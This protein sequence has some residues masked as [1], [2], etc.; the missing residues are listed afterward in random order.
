MLKSQGTRQQTRD[1]GGKNLLRLADVR[2]KCP[3]VCCCD[4]KEGC[5]TERCVVYCNTIAVR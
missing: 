3:S 1:I 2:V 5:D 4:V